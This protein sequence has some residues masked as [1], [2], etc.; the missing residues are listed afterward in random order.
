MKPER[1]CGYRSL[2]ENGGYEEENQGLPVQPRKPHDRIQAPPARDI[3]DRGAQFPG[4]RA[5]PARKIERLPEIA[6]GR[7]RP[8]CFAFQRQQVTLDVRQL[9]QTRA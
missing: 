9:G 7:C 5:L 4:E 6:F 1:W 8:S 3:E 2:L